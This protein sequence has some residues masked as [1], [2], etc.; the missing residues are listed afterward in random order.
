MS[1][2]YEIF[3]LPLSAWANIATFAAAIAAAIALG[4]MWRNVRQA[5]L[6]A[7]G[8]LEIG[9]PCIDDARQRGM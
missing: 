9:R 2:A 1:P 5:R 7:R 3:G 6:T 8:R 4:L